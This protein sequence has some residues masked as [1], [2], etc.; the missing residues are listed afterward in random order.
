MSTRNNH[1]PA[2]GTLHPVI[3]LAIITL[4]GWFVLSIWGFAGNG[5][6]DYLLAVVTGFVFVAVV[7]PCILWRMA[8]KRV[9]KSAREEDANKA[10]SFRDWAARDFTTWQDNV[11]GV[12]AAIEI[13]SPIAAVAFGMT[14]FAVVFHLSVRHAF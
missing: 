6:I 3:Y 4:A 10:R 1:P 5:R 8:S 2:R 14:A 12:N 7:I 11:K 13:L 9:A